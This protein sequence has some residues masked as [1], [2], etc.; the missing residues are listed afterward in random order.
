MN[1]L[2]APYFRPEYLRPTAADVL[3]MMWTLWY[4]SGILNVKDKQHI[5][6]IVCLCI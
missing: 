3:K 5:M 2:T 1:I 4:C 6:Y